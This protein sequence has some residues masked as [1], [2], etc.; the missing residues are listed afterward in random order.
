MKK[1]FSFIAVVLSAALIF[2]GCSS[3]S[4][5]KS[6]STSSSKDAGL[7]VGVVTDEGGAKDKSFNQSNV[8]A[9]EAWVKANGGTAQQPIETKSQDKIVPNL[10]TASKV[11]DVV[12][13][14]GFYFEKT[15]PE[16]AKKYTDKKFILL[17][18][19]VDEPNVESITFQ[20]N[21]AGY[22]AGYA[23]AL[24]SK[25]GKIGFIGGA[26][27]PPVVKFGIGFVQGAKAA[28][29]DIE[30][31]YN[32]SGTFNDTNKGKTLAATM[33]DSGADVIFAAAGGTGSGA[34]KEAQER[35]TN[36]LKES[37][38]IKHFIVGVDKDQYEDGIFKAKDKDGKDVEKSVIL[39]SAVKRID[40]AVT[41]A[42]DGIKAGTFKGGAANAQVL[43]IKDNG[44]GIPEK[45]PN[46]LEETY[47]KVMEA[48]E[49][50][51]SGEVKVAE[52]GDTLPNKDNIKGD[53]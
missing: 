18:A 8:E 44:V 31:F 28:N 36:D 20:E 43:S 41:K 32:Y 23:A 51:K 37:G 52:D 33:Y 49:K 14:A 11:S 12:S 13:I 15:L 25:T 53:L 38:E 47:K 17:D 27:I 16:V 6:T 24:Q 10:E 9:V 4:D 22:L 40:V 19:V 34:I 39:T 3:K 30:V 2:V 42:L 29:P 21:E 35:A 50:L 1:I 46:L 26:K 5:D 48:A 7:K 45:N